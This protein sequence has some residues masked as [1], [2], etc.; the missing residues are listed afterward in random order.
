MYGKMNRAKLPAI[1]NYL[2]DVETIHFPVHEKRSSTIEMRDR[3]V[4]EFP[5]RQEHA[6]DL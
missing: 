5:G 6:P 1:D 2:Q 3:I 4:P